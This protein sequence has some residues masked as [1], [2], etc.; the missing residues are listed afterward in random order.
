MNT[1]KFQRIE[2]FL[3]AVSSCNGRK[4]KHLLCKASND[5][6]KDVCEVVLNLMRGHIPLDQ[7]T[8]NRFKRESEALKPL[9][10]QRVALYKKRKIINQKG[11]LIG[12]VAAIALPVV[13]SLLL[14]ALKKKKKKRN[15]SSN[16]RQRSK[17][18]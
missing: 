6:I 13:A 7:V 17:G 12:H 11:G 16:R 8:F 2:S 3:Q 5:N 18:T 15:R 9:V 14:K 10:N 4:R 1:D